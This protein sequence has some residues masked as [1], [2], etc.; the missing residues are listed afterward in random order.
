[1]RNIE[2]RIE[3]AERQ[4]ADEHRPLDGD[5]PQ[6]VRIVYDRN[7]YGTPDRLP[8]NRPGVLAG[9][10]NS[11]SSLGEPAMIETRSDRK[12]PRQPPDTSTM[13]TPYPCFLLDEYEIDRRFAE[14]LKPKPEPPKPRR[15]RLRL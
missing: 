7:F 3:R 10:G 12:R 11:G 13:R 2:S 9:R 15:K 6:S 1:M 4:I 8:D 5:E 14:A